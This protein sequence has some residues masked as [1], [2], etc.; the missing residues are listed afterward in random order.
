MAPQGVPATAPPITIGIA[1]ATA[2][3]GN[4]HTETDFSGV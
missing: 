4:C 3:T 1:P 2:P